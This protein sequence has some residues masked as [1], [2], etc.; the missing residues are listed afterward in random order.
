MNLKKHLKYN[1]LELI[2]LI[3]Y[4]DCKWHVIGKLQKQ[5][6]IIKPNTRTNGRFSRFM[7]ILINNN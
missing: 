3:Y 7:H 6:Y 2:E 5:L 4:I 1:I